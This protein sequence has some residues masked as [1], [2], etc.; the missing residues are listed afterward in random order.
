MNLKC[1]TV[2]IDT[3]ENPQTHTHTHA[4]TD[5]NT[6]INTHAYTHINLHINTH[7]HTITQSHIIL[8]AIIEKLKA[9]SLRATAALFTLQCP[10]SRLFSSNPNLMLKVKKL[11]LFTKGCSSPATAACSHYSALK[12][13][14]CWTPRAIGHYHITVR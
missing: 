12:S 5:R 1:L 3:H 14:P 10:K 8:I 7:K 6:H 2:P 11:S 13:S 9:C 4:Q